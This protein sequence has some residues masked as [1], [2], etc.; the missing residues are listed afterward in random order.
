[1]DLDYTA[2]EIGSRVR[3][4]VHRSYTRKDIGWGVK[5]KKIIIYI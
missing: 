1:M 2:N 5:E 4:Q 3:A